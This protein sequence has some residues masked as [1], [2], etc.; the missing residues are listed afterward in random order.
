MNINSIVLLA[1]SDRYLVTRCTD[2]RL[3]PRTSCRTRL[4]SGMK[5]GCIMWDAKSFALGRMQ[6]SAT[7]CRVPAFGIR[8]R[9]P[10]VRETWPLRALSTP[11]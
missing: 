9:T 4:I 10:R 8:T 2:A 6:A 7:L 5:V 3:P 11:L 1:H